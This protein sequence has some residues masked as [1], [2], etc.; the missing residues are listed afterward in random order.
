[1]TDTHPEDDA[2]KARAQGPSVPAVP[3]PPP[4][5]LPRRMPADTPRPTHP[6]QHVAPESPA[7]LPAAGTEPETPRY[8]PRVSAPGEDLP[9]APPARRESPDRDVPESAT[10]AG[11]APDAAHP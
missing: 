8:E 6:A 4:P 2:R 11:H 1:M 7:D 3:P 5:V 10:L 9:G